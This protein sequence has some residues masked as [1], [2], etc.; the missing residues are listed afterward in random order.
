MA[1]R[2]VSFMVHNRKIGAYAESS[3]YCKLEENELY[4]PSNG[5]C[6]NPFRPDLPATFP[7]RIVMIKNPDESIVIK[8]VR[9]CTD[10]EGCSTTENG[11]VLAPEQV[12]RGNDENTVTVWTMQRF[13]C[14]RYRKDQLSIFGLWQEPEF[15][16]KCDD[17]KRNP[18]IVDILYPG[19]GSPEDINKDGADR[20]T[21]IHGLFKQ[22]FSQRY[23]DR[24]NALSAEVF[25]RTIDGIFNPPASE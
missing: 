4:R 10:Q 23:F 24:A 22:A 7:Y 1:E 18:D 2:L 11:F 14:E 12:Y 25:I 3:A 20:F 17:P 21:Y 15:Y 5:M 16:Y 9:R 19:L 6:V 8:E 13:G